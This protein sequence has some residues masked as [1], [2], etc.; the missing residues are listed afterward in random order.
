[1]PTMNIS[2]TEQLKG[3]V[4]ERVNSGKYTSASEYVRE[5]VRIDQKSREKEKLELQ[6]LE[7]LN[8]GEPV[9]VTSEMWASLRKKAGKR[10]KRVL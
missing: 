1:M 5:L 7:G 10:A 8:S 6:L 3:Y 2:L 4:E 9:T